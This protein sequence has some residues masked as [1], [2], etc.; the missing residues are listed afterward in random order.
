M[1]KI[2]VFLP[3]SKANADL[4][5]LFVS[6]HDCLV[7]V[8]DNAFVLSVEVLFKHISLFF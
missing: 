2:V 8:T 1:D 7:H 6:P 5:T 3:D 4:H